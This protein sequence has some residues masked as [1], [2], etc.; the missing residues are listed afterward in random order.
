MR[1]YVIRKRAEPQPV[2]ENILMIDDRSVWKVDEHLN[3]DRLS[4]PGHVT[5]SHVAF[6]LWSREAATGAL[7]EQTR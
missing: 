1:L 3:R 7:R 5:P 6:W 4:R 2:R